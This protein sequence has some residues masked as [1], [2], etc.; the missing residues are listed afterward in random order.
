MRNT[1]DQLKS[2]QLI[3][4]YEE[5]GR[6]K[7]EQEFKRVL[8]NSQKLGRSMSGLRGPR[9]EKSQ[10]IH[11]GEGQIKQALCTIDQEYMQFEN[12]E[13]GLESEIINKMRLLEGQQFNSSLDPSE[14]L[15]EL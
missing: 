7:A 10:F 3:G 2:P 9:N 4:K 6:Q 8:S 11:S 15:R 12:N 13:L 1:I 5:R 14:A